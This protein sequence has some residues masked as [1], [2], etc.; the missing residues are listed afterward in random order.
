M[1]DEAAFVDALRAAPG[2]AL[3]RLVY[4]DWLDERGDPRAEFLRLSCRVADDL[5]R[6]ADLRAGL[7]AD[8]AAA[9]DA[10]TPNLVVLRAPVIAD[11]T[12]HATVARVVAPAG[13][14]VRLDDP[15]VDIDNDKATF[16]LRADADGVVLAILVE[17]GQTVPVGAPLAVLLRS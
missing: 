10:F 4:A 12:A 2:D 15:V 3:A 9:A 11:S 5:R 7:P 17:V 1:D 8:W 6:L 14:R 16:D 13:W